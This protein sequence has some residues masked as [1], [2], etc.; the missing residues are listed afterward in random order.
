MEFSSDPNTVWDGFALNWTL[1]LAPFSRS[2]TVG[3]FPDT[4]SYF[5]GG[6]VSL[7]NSDVAI[8]SFRWLQNSVFD[9]FFASGGGLLAR[10][11]NVIVRDSYFE[12]NTAN[13]ITASGGAISA[14]GGR[15]DARLNLENCRFVSN[16]AAAAGFWCW[17]SLSFQYFISEEICIILI[18]PSPQ[19]TWNSWRDCAMSCKFRRCNS[20]GREYCN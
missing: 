15:E 12:M 1:V 17:L 6:A 14:F 13:G 10:G 4:V 11:G 20:A 3:S 18:F 16:R 2:G 8:V 5:A 9:T 19:H 7:L